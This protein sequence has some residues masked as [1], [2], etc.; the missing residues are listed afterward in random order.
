MVSP[1]E[2]SGYPS[3]N[4]PSNGSTYR[5]RSSSRRAF[6]QNWR[7]GNEYLP[8]GITTAGRPRFVRYQYLTIKALAPWELM[9]GPLKGI[10][11][12][13]IERRV[14]RDRLRVHED[15][16]LA[17]LHEIAEVHPGRPGGPDVLR[18]GRREGRGVPPALVRRVGA[19]AVRLGRP[20]VA[21]RTAN[22]GPCPAG[23]RQAEGT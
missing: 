17:A 7:E 9:R 4:R 5:S 11:D 15:E 13:P 8:V 20:G 12:I 10:D 1:S 14:Y 21:R 18:G 2:A 16:I 22:C 23:Q 19:G 6:H 3:R